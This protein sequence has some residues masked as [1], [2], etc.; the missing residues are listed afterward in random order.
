M[1]LLVSKFFA[2]VPKLSV[3]G[4]CCSR[5]WPTFFGLREARRTSRY[6]F[7]CCLLAG[8]NGPLSALY[9]EE[10]DTP[11]QKPAGSVPWAMTRNPISAT[12]NQVSV[13][14]GLATKI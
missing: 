14:L 5:T 4:R 8:R 13:A 3:H 2:S 7:Q 12:A 6:Q 11:L 9:F 10:S 1:P